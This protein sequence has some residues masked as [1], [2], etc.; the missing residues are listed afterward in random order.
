MLALRATYVKIDR[1]WISGIEHDPAKRALVAGIGNFAAE[2]GALVIAEGI[3]TE[4]ELET[5][6]SL[7]IHLGQGYLLGRPAPL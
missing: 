7:D 2:S 3:E 5:V 1:S 6:R 4:P